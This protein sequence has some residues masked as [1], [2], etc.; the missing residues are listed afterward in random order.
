V[1]TYASRTQKSDR[2]LAL[3]A[4]HAARQLHLRLFTE[5]KKRPDADQVKGD[6]ENIRD[7][8]KDVC[9][10]AG[11]REA[12]RILMAIETCRG[13]S[14]YELCAGDTQA[15]KRAVETMCHLLPKSIDTSP[16]S[17]ARNLVLK[18]KAA[19]PDLD[20]VQPLA[21]EFREKAF[22]THNHHTFYNA[23]PLQ[24][25]ELKPLPLTSEIQLLYPFLHWVPRAV[26][27][28][29]LVR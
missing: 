23:L 9:N 25:L 14:H 17:P 4:R 26:G 29:L 21:K 10:V 5:C 7:L 15:V 12:V 13:V 27:R 24:E 18:I 16:A 3:L 22:P 20:A 19:Q 2:L 11:G 1:E 6:V 28:G 8:T